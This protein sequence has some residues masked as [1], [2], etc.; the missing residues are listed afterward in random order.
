MQNSTFRPLF[1]NRA[2]SSHLPESTWIVEMELIPPDGRNCCGFFDYLLPIAKDL[3][4]RRWNGSTAT[5]FL[6][7]KI[8]RWL[9]DP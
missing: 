6:G 3:E 1:A 8:K 7:G 5:P 2:V 9:P 4:V